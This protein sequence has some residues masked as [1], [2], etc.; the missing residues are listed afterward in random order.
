MRALFFAAAIGLAGLITVNSSF[1]SLAAAQ[2][3]PDPNIAAKFAIGEV[4]SIEASNKLITIKT[5]AGSEVMVLFTDRTTYKKLAP[6][7]TS[8][9][10]AADITFA[11]VGQ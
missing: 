7:E 9:A 8:L 3:T 5:D 10:S 6:G 11:E 4:K 2:Q 1:T